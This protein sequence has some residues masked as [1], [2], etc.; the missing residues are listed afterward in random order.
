[1]SLNELRAKR[2]RVKKNVDKIFGNVDK[3][4]QESERVADVAHNAPLILTDLDNEFEAKTG[5]HGKD[6]AFLFAAIA[7]QAIR[8]V[9]INELTKIQNANDPSNKTENALQDFQ[10]KLLK[11]F[12]TGEHIDERPY[13][14]SMEHII[15]SKGVPYDATTTLTAKQIDKMMEKGRTWSFD[16]DSFIPTEDKLDLFKGANHRFSTLGHDPMLGLLFGTSNIM[17]NTITCSKSLSILYGIPAITTNHVIYSSDFKDPRIA[18]YGSTIWMFKEVIGRTIDQPS[19]FVASLIKQIIH[20]GTDLYTPCGIQIPG[21]NLILSNTN[22][23]KLTKFISAGDLLKIGVSTKLAGLINVLISTLHTLT[24][25]YSERISMD[26]Y[27]VRTRKIILYS[28]AIATGTNLAWVGANVIWGDKSQIRNLDLGG[29]MEFF[30]Q[31]FNNIGFRNKIK[32]E[33]VYGSFDNLIQGNDLDLE[34]VI[35]D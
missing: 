2:K 26:L 14:A 28:N 21:A 1:M 13:Y 7:L 31:L 11:K 9:V 18:T 33:F 8:I 22:V 30:R 15:T 35:W 23:E 19:A 32:E 16:I 12:N 25:D 29:L 4:A 10:N 17:T 34:E 20:I 5:L 6:I 27:N 3:I 24:Y